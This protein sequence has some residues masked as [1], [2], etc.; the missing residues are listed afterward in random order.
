[1]VKIDAKTVLPIIACFENHLYRHKKTG[2]VYKVI[3]G[4]LD[5]ADPYRALVIYKSEADGTVWARE[6]N[7]FC[8]G[9]FESVNKHQSDG[10]KTDD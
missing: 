6:A 5:E 8:D 3:C 9:R 7:E 10:G 2:G 4:A 1:M